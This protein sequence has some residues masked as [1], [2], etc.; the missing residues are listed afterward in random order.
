MVEAFTTAVDNDFIMNDPDNDRL[1][2]VHIIYFQNTNLLSISRHAL[3]QPSC[4][5]WRNSN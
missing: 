3:S 5:W 2:D 1:R 4:L